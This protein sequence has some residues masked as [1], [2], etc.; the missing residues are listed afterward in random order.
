MGE[1]KWRGKEEDELWKSSKSLSSVNGK[2]KE[3]S[4]EINDENLLSEASELL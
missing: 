4:L 1:K 3:P 2:V